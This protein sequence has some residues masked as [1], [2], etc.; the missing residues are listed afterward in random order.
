MAE[1]AHGAYTV[2]SLPKPLDADHGTTKAAP[3]YGLHG[4][5]KR[6][7]HEVAVGVDGEGVNIYNVQSQSIITS[8]AL[9]PHSYICCPPCSIHQRQS[10]PTK[11]QRHTYLV[12]RDGAQDAKRRL[13]SFSE[14]AGGDGGSSGDFSAPRKTE[15]RLRD[16]DTASV[17][18]LP[19]VS[20]RSHNAK[21]QVLVSYRDG[22]VVCVEDETAQVKWEE[23]H[24]MERGSSFDVEF[25]TLTDLQTARRG[26]LQGREDI[27]AQLESNPTRPSSAVMPLICRVV[28]SAA[29]RHF[30]VF[31]IQGARMKRLDSQRAGLQQIMN[32]QLPVDRKASER[33]AHYE[34]HAG[35]G[36]L[37]QQLDGRL[38]VYDLSATLPRAVSHFG[39][40]ADH[41]LDFARVSTSSLFVAFG[42][43]AAVYET[44]YG[45]V[46]QFLPLLGPIIELSGNKKRKRSDGETEVL[47]VSNTHAFAD[48]GLV[49]GVRGN[50][51]SGWQLSQDVSSKRAKSNGTMLRH[52]IGKDAL[53]VTSV[54]QAGKKA[55][56]WQA[57]QDQVDQ[58]VE[59]GNIRALEDFVAHDFGSAL[60][61]KTDNQLNSLALISDEAHDGSASG[62]AGGSVIS[63][64]RRPGDLRHLDRR[65]VFH[66]LS[67]MF[68]I[69]RNAGAEK[70]TLRLTS[71]KLMEWMALTGN[72][73][74]SCV[75]Q[76]L[77]QD[78]R[79][80]DMM[81][82]DLIP[83]IQ[84]S[85]H[86]FT[87]MRDLLELPVLWEVEE[88]AQ[89]LRLLVQSLD[90]AEPGELPA[91][92]Q[93][94]SADT[95]M[96]D[97]DVESH[98]ESES[99]LA[100]KELDEAMLMVSVELRS[101]TLRLVL[102]R[103]LT[104]QPKARTNAMRK[105]MSNKDL[106]FF[107][108]ILRIELAEGG[109]TS[110]YIDGG[111]EES[112][113]MPSLE[114]EAIDVFG[115]SNQ[116]ICDITALMICAVDAIGISGWTVG[117]SG[118]VHA[119][120]DLVNS[121]K[122]EIRACTEAC[123][124][125]HSMV[126][127]LGELE[128]SGAF[129]KPS[130]LKGGHHSVDDAAALERDAMLPLGSRPEAPVVLGRNTKQIEAKSMK[131]RAREKSMRV[132]K[133]SVDR[134][135][136]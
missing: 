77:Q 112:T 103:L 64:P 120:A 61:R 15:C 2:A 133:Y 99:A 72:L 59:S 118:D 63:A 62:K 98:I 94:E 51:L 41:V 56:D 132:G 96:N 10:K 48:V 71:G 11:A 6:K 7:R 127:L 70:I 105:L 123:H 90:D 78:G 1:G 81:P 66:L 67:L 20:T 115:P 28:R 60:S 129:A 39:S 50:E 95:A 107:I 88:V 130:L 73:S 49:V 113:E 54:R 46:Q 86:D 125:A 29:S 65:K 119:T 47:S 74:A 110:R 38:T 87:L 92:T 68:A 21:P 27:L 43:R 44:K 33:R 126:D 26:I 121:L 82:G 37:Y 30:Q 69:E 101:H 135:R 58:F 93:N 13:V 97:D 83:A 31:T 76:A 108:H 104:F 32:Y 134:I 22:A 131:A 85:S 114:G 34:L 53:A 89:A 55:D 102:D 52:A 57:W 117:L 106:I 80:V 111:E 79:S 109:W 23:Q 3:V 75:R 4:S 12:L 91:I 14:T 9:P 45:S 25:A 35:S 8:Y 36:R 40:K 84:Q 136:I 42:D 18:V 116:A 17:D 5:K 122:E 124:E 128:K 24:A 16:G 19:T 100:E